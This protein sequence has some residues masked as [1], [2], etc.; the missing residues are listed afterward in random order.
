MKPKQTSAPQFR[1]VECWLKDYT[2]DKTIPL[3]VVRDDVDDMMCELERVTM[4]KPTSAITERIVCAAARVDKL[5]RGGISMT[6]GLVD[7]APWDV[8]TSGDHI[9]MQIK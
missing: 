3:E 5:A 4:E 9:H 1:C 2:T 8:N 7:D 6:L